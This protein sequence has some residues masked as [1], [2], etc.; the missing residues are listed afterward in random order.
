MVEI[1]GTVVLL[2]VIVAVAVVGGATVVRLY[3]DQ[4]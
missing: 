1:V 3:R 4:D 2:L